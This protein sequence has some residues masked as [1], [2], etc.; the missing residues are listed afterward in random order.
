MTGISVAICRISR[1]NFK[2]QYLRNKKFFLDLLLHIWNV[3][4]TSFFSK[5]SK[6]DAHSKYAIKNRESFLF[7]RYW[8]LKLLREILHIATDIPVI[9]S[10][11][12]NK[13]S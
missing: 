7:L 6:F 2:H 5:C 10:H 12:A 3:H 9:G 13:Q 11:Y 1:N 8:C 4:Q